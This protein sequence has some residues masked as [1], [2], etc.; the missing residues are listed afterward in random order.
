VERPPPGEATELD[1]EGAPA[2]PA[3]SLAAIAEPEPELEPGEHESYR[4]IGRLSWPVMVSLGLANVV[5]LVDIAMVGRLGQDATAA[6]G[7]ATQFHFLSQSVLLAVGFACTALMTRAI[8]AGDPRRARGA[9]GASLLVAFGSALVIVAFVLAPGAAWLRLLGADPGVAAITLPYMEL[10]IGST[11]FLSVAMTFEFGM[12]ADR[13]TR[14]PLRIV[15]VVAAVKIALN[16]VLIFGEAGFPRLE[17]V[18]AGVATVVSQIVGLALFGIA[19]ARAPARGLLRPDWRAARPL[20][21]DV[22]RLSLPGLGE[23]LAMNLA[24]L[25][26]FR[27]L[28]E[29]GT[30]AVAAYTVGIRVLSFSW[31]PG[32]GFGVASATLVG[33]ALGAGNREAAVRAGW[34]T[35]RLALGVAVVLGIAGGLQRDA[36]AQLFVSDPAT[37]AALEPFLLCLAV[38]QPFIQAHFTLGGVHRGAGDTL[39]PFY[40]AVAGNWL[41][42]VP[43]A[44]LFAWVWKL[45]LIWIWYAI[46]VDHM[47][48]AAWLAFSFRRGAWANSLRS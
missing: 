40:A 1:P 24:L 4:E 48:R 34:R 5:G 46:L 47:A 10:V 17:L 11:L 27:V 31:L 2:L 22:V 38:T 33:Q 6:V 32:S 15:A 9:L 7:Y 18:G 44:C 8:G 12:R 45:D 21:R 25:V 19:A 14:T 43:L 26:Y 28:A 30:A 16:A 20:M 35:T 42:R 39:T 41:L 3:G 29:Y 13:D 37:L 23:R 36:L